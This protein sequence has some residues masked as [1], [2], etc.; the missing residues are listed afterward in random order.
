MG[1]CA[2]LCITLAFG[3]VFIF[4]AK[5]NKGNSD[6]CATKPYSWQ[7]WYYVMGGCYIAICL[8]TALQMEA[9]RAMTNTNTVKA[10]LYKTQ[11]G[12]DADVEACER[13]GAASFRRGAKLAMCTMCTMCPVLIFAAVWSCIGIAL[14]CNSSEEH[15]ECNYFEAWWL[16]VTIGSLVFSCCASYCCRGVG[17]GALAFKTEMASVEM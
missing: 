16:G 5:D 9:M 13:A 1:M 14:Y 6:A 15:E 10:Q 12:R 11:E 2:S 7:K 4:I 8:L 3:V 17:G